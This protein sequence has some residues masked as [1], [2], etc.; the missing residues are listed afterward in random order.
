MRKILINGGK[1][2]EGEVTISGSKNAALPILA[3]TVLLSSESVI[4]NI[5]SLL[6]VVTMMR[7]LRALGLRAEYYEPDTVKIW[8][9]GGVKHV[10]PYE[11]VTKM[12]ASFFVI[13][14]ILA[15]AKLAKV[16]L[17]GGCAIGSRPVNLHIKG[18]EAMGA[19]VSIEHGFVVA[20]AD[21]LHGGNIYLDFPSV[22]ATE[23][24][25]MAATLANGITT[26]ENAAQEPEIVDLANFLK[27]AGANIT[28]AGS[29][30][31]TIEGVSELKGVEHRVIPDRIEAGTMIAAGAIT[32]G[33]IRVKGVIPEH[34]DPFVKKLREA[35]LSIDFDGHTAHVASNGRLKAVDVKTMPFPGFPTD[36]QPQLTTLMALAEG[37]SVITETV[38]ESR[39]MYVQEL[40]RMGANIQVEEHSAIVRGVG[41]LSSAPI[42]AYDLRGGAAL[43]LAALS[44][45]G[46][47]LIED[48]E[49]YIERGYE[50]LP[51]KLNALGAKVELVG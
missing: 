39:F 9:N 26:I 15:R 17:P 5:P 47:T 19:Q 14:P 51:E 49:R 23:S 45:D 10:A 3:A 46:E 28:G 31:I 29:D 12:R 6:D 35:G 24:I 44:A 32:G 18:F 8:P 2:L 37:T 38:F 16:P 30:I 40:K 13:G 1:R 20:K 43:V 22:G 42:R 25:M 27:L 11:L 48:N 21:E 50:H 33:D 4:R 7:V 41:S 36:M 34:L